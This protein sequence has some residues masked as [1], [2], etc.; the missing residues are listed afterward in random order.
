MLNLKDSDLSQIYR[1]FSVLLWTSDSDLD[2]CV[3]YGALPSYYSIVS[4]GFILEQKSV[5]RRKYMCLGSVVVRVV[6]VWS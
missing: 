5:L 1:V 6:R 2:L 4:L 3:E